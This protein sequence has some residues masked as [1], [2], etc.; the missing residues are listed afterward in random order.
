MAT[1]NLELRQV[2][3]LYITHVETDSILLSF[4]S[5]KKFLEKLKSIIIDINKIKHS[6]DIPDD[7]Y[8]IPVLYK[9]FQLYKN[10]ELS[11]YRYLLLNELNETTLDKHNEH[12]FK[13]VRKLTAINGKPVEK[14]VLFESK[15]EV[16]EAYKCCFF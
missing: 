12:I 1:K 16:L 7:H 2:P 8:L 15:D 9:L 5:D 14:K 11:N 6:E 10:K 3:K 13:W 4:E